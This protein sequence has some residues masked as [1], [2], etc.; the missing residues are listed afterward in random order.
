MSQ[1]KPEPSERQGSGADGERESPCAEREATGIRRYALVLGEPQVRRCLLG[2]LVARLAQGMYP[3][4]MLLTVRRQ[5]EQ[6]AMAG[7]VVAC[8][9]VAIAVGS[10]VLGR[11]VDRHGGIVLGVCALA[12]PLS[13]GGLVVAAEADQSAGLLVAAVVAGALQPPVTPSLRTLLT[14]SFTDPGMRTAAFGVDAVSVELSFVVGPAAVGAALAWGAPQ[15]ALLAGA[16]LTTAGTLLFLSARPVPKHRPAT[17]ATG[18]G[19]HSVRRV[20]VVWLVGLAGLAQMLAVGMVEVGVSARALE[21]DAPALA[22]IC[23]A[24]W[25]A[26][27]VTGGLVFAARSWRGGIRAQYAAVSAGA[28]TGFALLALPTA[29]AP[30]AALMFVAGLATTPVA[31]L[32]GTALGEGVPQQLRTE[33]FAWFASLSAA[34]GSLGILVGGALADRLTARPVFLLAVTLPLLAAVIVVAGLGRGAARDGT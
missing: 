29:S 17:A 8:F 6:F 18:S 26:G 4:A 11:L 22:G 33:A 16:V 5:A 23:L 15:L 34:G 30:M 32:A 12:A 3:V 10:P 31:T 25:A 13:I 24:L 20:R 14:R 2:A 9:G 1:G 27:S 7:L 28:A 21:L 19:R